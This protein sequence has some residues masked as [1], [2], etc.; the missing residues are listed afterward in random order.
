MVLL[1]DPPIPPDPPIP[2]QL[3]AVAA[4]H[5]ERGGVHDPR[6]FLWTAGDLER[7]VQAL[8]LRG[9]GLVIDAGCGW[10]AL[11]LLVALRLPA[12]RVLGIDLDRERLAVAR[13]IAGALR[14]GQRV[15]WEEGDLLDLDAGERG[16]AALIGQ[17]VLSHQPRPGAFLAR[18]VERC[19]PGTTVA[20]VE[21]DAVAVA[22]AVRDS[23]TDGDPS[24]AEEREA[25]ARAVARG[26]RD[27]LAVDRRAGRELA[28]WLDDAGL[29]AIGTAVMAA[30]TRL[31]PPYRGDEPGVVWY[32]A[33]LQ[34]RIADGVDPV[35]R[36]LAV[37]GGWSEER[38]RAW[39]ARR[40]EADRQR[41]AALQRG[42]WTRD[43]RGGWIQAWGTVP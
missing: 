1:G 38:Y 6:A 15:R 41:L 30:E 20:F 17:A 34:R 39:C 13:G 19:S 40:V 43:E 22:R 23:V 14:L 21:P 8:G 10:G 27:G 5:L 7:F 32:R 29:T 35:E 42:A 28:G 16:A 12:V 33:A 26:A 9:G 3:R 37:A 31:R 18:L 4:P 2:E 36:G 11:G 24:F 25:A